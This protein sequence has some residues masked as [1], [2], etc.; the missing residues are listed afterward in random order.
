MSKLA[1][2]VALLTGGPILV[3]GLHPAQ[4][5]HRNSRRAL[6]RHP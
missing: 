1:E 2:K 5:A 6:G 3:A 4:R